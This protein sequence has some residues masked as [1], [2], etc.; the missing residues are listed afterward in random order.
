MKLS[1]LTVTTCEDY[2][3]RFLR[4]FRAIADMLSAEFVV[5]HDRC[6]PPACDADKYVPVQSSGVVEDVLVEAHRACS[7]DYVLRL[8]DD[9]TLSPRAILCV[10]EW[11]SK[12]GD[13][14]VY[15][16]PRANLWGDQWHGIRSGSLFPDFQVRL[17]PRERECRFTVHEGITPD[18]TLPGMILHHKFLLKTREERLAIAARYEG[19]RAGCGTGHYLQFSVPEDCFEI[20]TFGFFEGSVYAS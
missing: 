20:E 11:L 3:P 5:A 15:A 9:E 19:K 10:A 16:F 12:E 6:G 2:T 18:A 1:I 7:G 17:M 4:H 8:D 13:S 14:S